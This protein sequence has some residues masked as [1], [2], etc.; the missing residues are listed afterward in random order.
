MKKDDFAKS[1][2]EFMEGRRDLVELS[3]ELPDGYMELTACYVLP[4]IFLACNDVH[5]RTVPCNKESMP[6]ELL[7]INYCMQGRCEFKV[8]E[9]GYN[10]VDNN[11]MNITTQ[12]AQDYFYYPSSYYV[13]YEVYV[14]PVM[15][16]EKTEKTLELFDIEIEAMRRTYERGAAFYAS[17]AML[18]LWNHIA[19]AMNAGNTG[20]LR[21]DVLQIL[22]YF[23]DYQ[24]LTPVNTMYLSK[25]QT[26]LAKRAQAMLVEDLSRHLSVKLVAEQLGVSETSLKR[27]FRFVY[28][29]N[30][31]T[32]MN[33]VRMEY[34]AGLLA[35][36]GFSV[37]D[38]AKACGYV[39]QGRFARVF[40]EYYGMKPLDYRRMNR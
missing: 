1:I 7:L 36:T 13:G 27:Y 32:Y 14:L 28:G 2:Q 11:M 10:Y 8:D 16:T 29:A 20:Q 34:A 31:S 38:I 21:L 26:M 6:E 30:I 3:Q 12:M 40:R 4:G 22:K 25:A 19:E 15:F 37:S 17:D 9:D 39:N 18:K 35:E 33:E 24:P 5:A 23:Q